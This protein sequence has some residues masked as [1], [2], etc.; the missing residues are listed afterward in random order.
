M[1]LIRADANERIGAGHIMRCLS[2]GAAFARYGMEFLF[3]TADHK[4]DALLD[5][6]G[7][8][9]ICLETDWAD[10]ET[11]L[12]LMKKIIKEKNPS[13]LLVDSYRVTEKYFNELVP[14]IKTAYMDDLNQIRW[15]VETLINYNIYSVV[16]DYSYYEGTR[17][18]LGP[19]YAP[20]REE[21][22][23]LPRHDVGE[24]KHVMVSAGG[25][26]PEGITEKI[27]RE[28]CPDW[29][30]VKF[31]FIVGALNPRI[32]EIKALKKENIILHIN[33][34]NM[35]VLMRKCDIA[36]SAA[37]TTLYELCAAGIPSIIFTLADNQLT[38]AKQ[39][40]EKGIMVNLGDC[41]SNDRF[42]A[43]LKD[44]LKDLMDD[45]GERKSLSINMQKLVDGQGADRIAAAL[46]RRSYQIDKGVYECGVKT[47][48]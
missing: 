10:M 47:D 12:P 39:F 22:R 32:N 48:G 20:L 23:S 3:I 42:I 38:A 18:L 41:R 30:E 11:E 15:N 1:I 43:S 13:L 33:E 37:G 25:A 6:N 28:V 8:N 40:S 4:G 27:I 9:H 2:I 21:F 36:I 7:V 45:P 19:K 35:S 14:F 26:D 31:H 34:K 24:I 29:P 44:R 17:L 16:F 46:K 5:Q